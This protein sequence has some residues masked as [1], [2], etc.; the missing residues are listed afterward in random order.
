MSESVSSLVSATGRTLSKQWF[1]VVIVIW[2]GQAV[3]MITSYAAGYAAVWY[4]TETTGSALML[5]L[6]SICAYLPQGLLAPLGGVVADR[7]NRKTVMI[8]TSLSV[9]TVSCILGFTI[10]MGHVSIPLI[11][12]MVTMRSVG[13]AFRTPAMMAAMPMLVPAKHMLRINTLDQ[14]L[15]SIAAIG[16]PAFG[17]FLYTTMGFYAV[18]FLDVAGALIAV[19]GLILAKIPTVCSEE[20]KNQRILTNLREG[21]QALSSTQGLLI[22]IVGITLGMV[23]F[24]PLGALFPLMTYSYFGGDGYMASITEAAFGIGMFLG[25]IV[26]MTWGGGKRL[27]GLIA[28]SAVIVGSATAACGL[29]TPDMFNMFVVLCGVMA[30][31]CAGFNGPLITLVQRN[32]PAEKMGRALGLTTASFGLASPLGIALGGALAQAI[33]VAPF[34]LVDGL[35]CLAL[36]LLIYLPK[37]VRALDHVQDFQEI[38]PEPCVTDEEI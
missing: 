35:L 5:S 36:G 8:I 31:A 22:L 34:F 4:I 14:L 33:G 7:F 28:V 25:S 1:L 38:L 32:V 17:I 37:S 20:S 12:I 15:I 21:W 19:A 3:S 30:V 9:G 29:L 24:S 2:T 26:L 6:A 13:L 16:A 18:M 11:M 27:A 10:L 23:V